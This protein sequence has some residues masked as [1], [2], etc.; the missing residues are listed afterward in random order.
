[1]SREVSLSKGLVKWR[2]SLCGVTDSWDS[3]CELPSAIEVS[4]ASLSSRYWKNFRG[5]TMIFFFFVVRDWFFFDIFLAVRMGD[6]GSGG[7][8]LPAFAFERVMTIFSS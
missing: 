8:I 6:P 7:W 4:L 1:M 2:S 5:E 3:K